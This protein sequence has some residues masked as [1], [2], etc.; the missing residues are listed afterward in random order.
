METALGD[1]E[2]ASALD[3]AARS[4]GG[5]R[6][7]TGR[8]AGLGRREGEAKLGEEMLDPSGRLHLVAGLLC[9]LCGSRVHETPYLRYAALSPRMSTGS[10]SICARTSGPGAKTKVRTLST[11]GC[12]PPSVLASRH[13]KPNIWFERSAVA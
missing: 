4:L 3:A 1:D 13:I 8:L 7:D 11:R 2:H 12:S 6:G 9:H 10:S 5:H